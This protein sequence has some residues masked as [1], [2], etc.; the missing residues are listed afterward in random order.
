MALNPLDDFEFEM[1]MGTQDNALAACRPTP[2]SSK[3]PE[4]YANS[5]EIPYYV[6]RELAHP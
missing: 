1:A 6:F 3:G 2:P 5:S 4:M